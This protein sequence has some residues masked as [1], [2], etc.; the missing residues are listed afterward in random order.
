MAD[1]GFTHPNVDFG[2]ILYVITVTRND[3]STNQ[4]F[5]GV[6]SVRRFSF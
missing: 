1:V 6:Q 4:Y 2:N 5:V 3:P